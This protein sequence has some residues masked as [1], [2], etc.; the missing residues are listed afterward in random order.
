MPDYKTHVEFTNLPLGFFGFSKKYKFIHRWLDYPSIWSRTKHRGYAHD[1]LVIPLLYRWARDCGE[2]PL[3]VVLTAILHIWLD[4][5]WKSGTV[6]KIVEVVK[7]LKS[8][9]TLR[10]FGDLSESSINKRSKRTRR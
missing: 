6:Q 9:E 10:K 1:Y 7:I 5:N 2:D 8:L 4:K 3:P